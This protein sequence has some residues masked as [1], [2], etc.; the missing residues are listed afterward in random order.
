[1][2]AVFFNIYAIVY[3]WKP[4]HL[5]H[6]RHELHHPHKHRHHLHLGFVDPSHSLLGN[7]V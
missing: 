6:G 1:M 4:A 2:H 3:I 7:K 5:Y